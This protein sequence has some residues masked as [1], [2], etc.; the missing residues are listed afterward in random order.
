M[1]SRQAKRRHGV[2]GGL[3]ASDGTDT[4]RHYTFGN[5]TRFIRPG[6]TRVDITGDIPKDVLLSA[7]RGNATVVIVAINK[8]AESVT[9]PITIAGGTA[10]ASLTPWVTSASDNLKSKAAVT[11]SGNTF[12]PTLAGK[13]VTTFVGNE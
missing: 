3:L 9:V 4:K 11:V 6:Y 13:T 12:T 5:F 1:R 8:G 7:Y 2:G 10:P